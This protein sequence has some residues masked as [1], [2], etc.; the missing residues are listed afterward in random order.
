MSKQN[1]IQAK[2]LEFSELSRTQLIDGF[3][4]DEYE[5]KGG[6]LSKPKLHHSGGELW[7]VVSVAQDPIAN[8]SINHPQ[9]SIN[10]TESAMWSL[11]LCSCQI[12][13]MQHCQVSSIS[14]VRL[15][16][17]DAD[18]AADAAAYYIATADFIGVSRR[19]RPLRRIQTRSSFP[20]PL[21]PLFS[22]SPSSP[23]THLR[24]ALVLVTSSSPASSSSSS[25]PH[26]LKSP[27]SRFKRKKPLTL[28]RWKRCFTPD[29]RLRKRGVYL[30]KKVRSRGIDPSIRSEV[31][32]FLLGVCD[33]NSSKEERGAT[34]TQRRLSG[35]KP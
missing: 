35:L 17:A 27:W 14:P 28:R 4:I 7:V 29:G 9:K 21:S 18:A 1:I 11:P 15:V 22:S 16:A 23:W 12:Q 20:N 13:Y 8:L 10:G 6:A 5:G 34:R 24:S 31:W 33:L 3:E 19:T 26:R 30:L 2:R 25:N 32:P